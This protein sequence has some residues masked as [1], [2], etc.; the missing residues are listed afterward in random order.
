[1][2]VKYWVDPTH[3]QQYSIAIEVIIWFTITLQSNNVVYV[4]SIM[5][6]K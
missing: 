3:L 4:V 6:E 5:T 1:M 2:K